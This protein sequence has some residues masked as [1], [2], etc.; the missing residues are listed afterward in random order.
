MWNTDKSGAAKMSGAA[1]G[2]TL[3]ELIVVILILSILGAVALPRFMNTAGD[4]RAAVMKAVAGSMRGANSMLYAK[5]ASI[6]QENAAS[7]TVTLPAGETVQLK[8]G[9]A[10]TTAELVK[11]MDIS[12][13]EDFIQGGTALRHAKANNPAGCQVDFLPPTGPGLSPTY[14]ASYE[15]GPNGC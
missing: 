4:A 1:K 2:F 3:I 5:A 6:G 11:A 8:Y 12:P 10:A 7:Y 14:T 9:Y 13:P 15:A